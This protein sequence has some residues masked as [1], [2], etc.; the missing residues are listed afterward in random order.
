MII[1]M[2]SIWGRPLH[3]IQDYSV[4]LILRRITERLLRPVILVLLPLLTLLA[5]VSASTLVYGFA[6]K[7]WLDFPANLKQ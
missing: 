1:G 5:G 2:S 7:Y 4:D 6:V 3:Y